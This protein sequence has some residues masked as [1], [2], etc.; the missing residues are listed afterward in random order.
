MTK[1][2]KRLSI[3]MLAM[4]LL[5]FGSTTWI[6]VISAD[7]LGNNPNNRRALYDSFQVQRGSI[8]AGGAAIASSVP[9]DDV[10]AWQRVYTDPAMW[11]PVTGYF[12]PALGS[13]TGIEQAMNPELS[14]TDST[15]FLSRLEQIVT[16]QPRKGANV[17]LTLD[18]AVQKAA[19]DALGSQQG[20][21][22]AIEPKTGRILA[23]VTSP[24]YDTNSLAGHDTSV[25]NANYDALVANATHPL[26]NRAIAGD[27]NPP[28]S[29]F[30]L[31]TTSAA[32]ASASTPRSRRCPTPRPISC[33]SRRATCTTRGA[34][35]A[36]AAMSSRS[37]TRSA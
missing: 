3:L 6:Q 28:G 31:V 18:P 24:S 4:F 29:T 33:R 2:L 14:G 5:L 27:M 30:K 11:A 20:A 12:N 36:G 8:V 15:Q 7:A 32:L 10:Y 25:V 23:M 22:V 35:R 16:G 26:Y 9:T 13:A 37:P 1:E 19:F 17:V 21:I 34:A